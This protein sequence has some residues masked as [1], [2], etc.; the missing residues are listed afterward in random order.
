MKQKSSLVIAKFICAI[1]ILIIHTNPFGSYSKALSFGFRN[2]V[3]VIAVP[4]FFAT[5]GYLLMEK[6]STLQSCREQKGYMVKYL[7]R[8]LQIY[9]AWSAV[10]FP[11]VVIKWIRKGFHFGLVLEYVKDFI[12]EGSYSTIWFLPALMVATAVFFLLWQKLGVKKVFFVGCGFYAVTLLL[13]SYYGITARIPGL[14]QLGSLYYSFFD[15][16]KNGML[17]G[18]IFVSLG[19]L[20]QQ[21]AFFSRFTRKQALVGTV[22]SYGLLCA[23]VLVYKVIGNTKGIDTVASLIPLTVCAMLFT[24]SFDVQPSRLC[25][26]LRKY[27]MLIFLC[28]RLPISVIDLFLSETVLATNTVVNCVTVSAA[29]FGISFV[30]LK[31]S[32]KWTWLKKVF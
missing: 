17:F 1:L 10:Y 6:L 12:F 31:L 13:S 15:S 30:I 11:F 26:T 16:V 29:T 19:A 8:L 2:V 18:L 23:E 32:E 22:L 7:K 4:F 3:C 28:Q 20:L 9:L 14:A 24:L 5:S 27:S 25:L 21:E